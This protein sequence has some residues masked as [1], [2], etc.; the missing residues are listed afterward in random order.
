MAV[1]TW[2][3]PKKWQKPAIDAVGLPVHAQTSPAVATTAAT[4][5]APT[6]TATAAPV[7][8]T[9]YTITYEMNEGRVRHDI[10]LESA[11]PGEVAFRF[12]VNF[13]GVTG[14]MR[15]SA[16]GSMGNP[17]MYTVYLMLPEG[18]TGTYTSALLES[19]AVMV[20]SPGLERTVEITAPTTTAA[21]T[22]ASTTTADTTTAS[23]TTADTT[24]A[25][26][27][28]G[29]LVGFLGMDLTRTQSVSAG[30][31]KRTVRLEPVDTTL[32]TLPDA[33]TIPLRVADGSD[34]G[35][36]PSY[37]LPEPP[38]PFSVTFAANTPFTGMSPFADMSFTI[39]IIP[40]PGSNPSRSRQ[41]RV[42]FDVGEGRPFP[43][44]VGPSPSRPSSTLF[45]ILDI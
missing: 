5:E 6:T 22:T 20:A 8:V 9:T 16:S 26:P 13:G 14:I 44:G 40:V 12:R 31:F 23:T 37:T 42:E 3:L 11:V 27:M 19:D 41:F 39:T 10:T 45:Q 1:A 15:G 4:T 36:G 2:L 43:E 7:G 35:I 28:S 25:A 32:T 33:V 21:T 24:T 34:N 38:E 17:E 18:V 29:F 30:S